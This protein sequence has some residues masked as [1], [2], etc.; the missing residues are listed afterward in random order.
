MSPECASEFRS[1]QSFKFISINFT[2]LL[3]PVLSRIHL[4]EI[5]KYSLLG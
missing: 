2:K 3:Y 1:E 5:I 4:F